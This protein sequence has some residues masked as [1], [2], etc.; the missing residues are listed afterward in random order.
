MKCD[1]NIL[2]LWTRYD[3][4]GASSRLRYFAYMDYFRAS[5]WIPTVHPFFSDNYLHCLYHNGH[6]SKIELLK[7]LLKR[8][9]EIAKLEYTLIIEYELFP[10][11]PAGW[12]LLFLKNRRWFLNFDDA[13][14][15]KY[16]HIPWLKNKF[17]RLCAKATGVIVANDHLLSALKPWN[18]RII[19]IPTVI[20]VPVGTEE[21]F[22][23]PVIAWIGTPVTY[24][25]LQSHSEALRAM[26]KICDYELLVI[27]QRGLPEIPGVNIKF[28]DWSAETEMR[29]L[30]RCHA[31]IMPLDDD[32]FSQGKSAFKLIQYLA[33]GIP[34]IASP[35]GENMVVMKNGKTGFFATTPAEW[36][37][38]WKKL[39]QSNIANTIADNCFTEFQKYSLCNY[40]PKLLDFIN[41]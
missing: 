36:A 14:W 27:A 24:K 31:G 17:T 38:A 37:E 40:A 21:K 5:G 11:F 25:Y 1:K 9:L 18:Q 10:Y 6:K 34:A 28:T 13:V 22:S 39:S 33:A 32:Q 4:L 16:S 19:K 2:G 12:E 7:S 15:C 35:V 23:H 41:S 3:K 20:D 8:Q 29:Y 30:R 26:R